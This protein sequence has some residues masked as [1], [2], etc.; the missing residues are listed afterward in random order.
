METLRLNA[1]RGK[2][3]LL[4][5]AALSFWLFLFGCGNRHP[6]LTMIPPEQMPKLGTPTRLE[7]GV[8]FSDV[9]L[10]RGSVKSH[11][12]VYLPEKAAGRKL[13]CI[14]IAPAGSR[15]FH[16]MDLADGDRPEHLPYVQAGYAVVAYELDGP[17]P[18]DARSDSQIIEAARAFQDAKAGLANA[19]LALDFI[20]QRL[21]QV[22]PKR[23]YCAGHSSAATL[24]L[25][26]AE[27]QPR[28]KACIAFA[29]VTDLKA[30]MGEEAI[31]ALSK[32][33]P[34]YE[35]FITDSSPMTQPAQLKCPLFLFHAED[36]SN[37][38]TS[39][40]SNFYTAVTKTNK[41]VTGVSVKTGDH[42]DSMVQQGI[43]R[44]IQ[45]LKTL[46]SEQGHP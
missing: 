9:V 22:D 40:V 16:G 36:D 38:P 29:P 7:N 32:H 8:L 31:S 41:Q 42:Y 30:R 46:P 44:A 14:L 4:V 24:S 6:A 1:L 39:E 35:A 33:L 34:N 13:G 18:Q 27:K 23:I 12:W 43:P 21:P 3:L 25:L 26:L 5:G 2:R 20:E 19:R 10:P 28:I 37:V 11:L 17:L 15:L 45:W